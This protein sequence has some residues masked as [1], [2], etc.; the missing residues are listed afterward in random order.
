MLTNGHRL[1]GQDER[2]WVEGMPLGDIFIVIMQKA[3]TAQ[4]VRRRESI[5][6]K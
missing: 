1:G 2:G 5:S 3:W 4:A 6:P